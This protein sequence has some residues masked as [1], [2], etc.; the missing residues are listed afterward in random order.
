MR[1]IIVTSFILM[2][3]IIGGTMDENIRLHMQ[4]EALTKRLEQ[5]ADNQIEQF[6]RLKPLPVKAFG[7]ASLMRGRV[8]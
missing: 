8:K 7:M 3:A 5:R 6:K 2:A 1:I 4:V